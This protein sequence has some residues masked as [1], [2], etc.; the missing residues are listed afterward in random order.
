MDKDYFIY[1]GFDGSNRIRV[2][3]LAVNGELKDFLCQYEA[4]IDEIWIPIVRYDCAHGQ[5]FHRDVML[6]NGDKEK[7]F[8]AMD[9]LKTALDYAVQDL[10]FRWA[11]YKERFLSQRRK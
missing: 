1:L 10:K 6:P 8:V 4:L 2:R 11:W 7:Q 3:V 9:S 5:S